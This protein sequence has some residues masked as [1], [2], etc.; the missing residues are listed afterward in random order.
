MAEIKYQIKGTANTGPISTTAKAL[1]TLSTSSSGVQ[2]TMMGLQAA[3]QGSVTAMFSLAR[4]AKALW[5]AFQA[6]SK[7]V[8]I[9]TA[10]AA[11]VWVV[12]RAWSFFSDR[13][14][15]A[16][17][18]ADE[19]AKKTDAFIAR[20][21]QLRN[22]QAEIAWDA[23]VKSLQK[24]AGAYDRAAKAA[25]GLAASQAEARTIAA[26]KE[27]SEITARYTREMR[28]A[29]PEDEAGIAANMQREL[30]AARYAAQYRELQAQSAGV[31]ESIAGRKDWGNTLV[32]SRLGV[33]AGL[34]VRESS[35]RIA[36]LQSQLAGARGQ[37]GKYEA[38]SKELQT[39]RNHHVKLLDLQQQQIQSIRQQ[40]DETKTQIGLLEEKKKRISESLAALEAEALAN[41]EILSL[42]Q[43]RATIQAEQKNAADI[44]AARKKAL[45]EEVEGL[46]KVAE[47][48]KETAAA[49]RA[50]DAEKLAALQ[51]L[52][53]K[54]KTAAD[55][56]RR[57]VMDPQYRRD[58]DNAARSKSREDRIFEQRYQRALRT[59]TRGGRLT[60]DTRDMLAAGRARDTAS[61]VQNAAFALEQQ[62]AADM[63]ASKAYLKTIDERIEKVLTMT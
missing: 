24:L 30:A 35:N 48:E 42:E 34:P 3:S 59:E 14:T 52:Q 32:A 39:A 28:T 5:L 43:K 33:E 19:A 36:G 25:E 49:R 27:E 11:A 58:Q 50:A 9:L 18:A 8:P 54:T 61:N 63:G 47:Q 29:A 46:K 7:M 26:S 17:A 37:P 12:S 41:N 56:A 44:A 31:D 21:R 53:T 38:I 2:D 4:G 60:K 62:M 55:E 1:D 16:T 15:A 20:L 45:D 6:G 57:R 40:E 51:E 23:Q 13:Q 22:V 10:I